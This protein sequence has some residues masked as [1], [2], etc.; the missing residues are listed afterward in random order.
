MNGEVSVRNLIDKLYLIENANVLNQYADE[1]KPL[2]DEQTRPM[3]TE[4]AQ[5]WAEKYLRSI[6][7][8]PHQRRSYSM[9]TE[10][11]S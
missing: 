4:V 8:S 11:K 6:T 9:V 10:T 5:G 2:F 3:P 7:P 1:L